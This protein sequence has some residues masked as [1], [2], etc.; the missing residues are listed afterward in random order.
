LLPRPVGPQTPAPAVAL[1]NKLL[2][3]S[4][5]LRDGRRDI[6]PYAGTVQAAVKASHGPRLSG[7]DEGEERDAVEKRRIPSCNA[8]REVIYDTGHPAESVGNIECRN[9]SHS[10]HALRAPW[11][12]L[13]DVLANRVHGPYP[14]HDDPTLLSTIGF[15][16]SDSPIPW[17]FLDCSSIEVPCAC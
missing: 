1:A 5:D 9:T 8:G 14:G 16:C 7:R 2:L 15:H 4:S 10:G 12:E 3:H 17:P 11:P 13:L 6:D